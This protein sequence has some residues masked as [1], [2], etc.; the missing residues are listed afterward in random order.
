MKIRTSEDPVLREKTKIVKD[1]SD[2][3]VQKLVL[4]MLETMKIEKG[5]GLAAP[6]IGSDLKICVIDVDGE[7]HILINPKITSKSKNKILSEEGC[8]SFPGLFFPISRYEEVQVR[9]INQK[10]E[11]KKLKGRDLLSRALQHEIDHL[12]G[13]LFIDR[14]KKKD[15]KKNPIL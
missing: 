12:N 14:I 9:F 15:I 10:G 13:I 1:P 7:K 4:D 6:Q 3:K 8:L 2:P 5:V 11:Q